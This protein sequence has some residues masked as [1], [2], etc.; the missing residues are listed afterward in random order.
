[1]GSRNRSIEF[2]NFV[3]NVRQL[4]KIYHNTKT[5]FQE[6]TK[7]GY[8][9]QEQLKDIQ[10][11]ED[12]NNR[13]QEIIDIC[14]ELE[15]DFDN[16][17]LIKPYTRQVINSYLV[18]AATLLHDSHTKCLRMFVM[19]AF[20]MT[21]DMMIT[22]KRIEYAKQNEYHLYNSLMAIANRK[23]EEIKDIISETI[24]S[25]KDELIDE[26][27]NYKFKFNNYLNIK[28]YTIELSASPDR[29]I[30]YRPLHRHPRR[31]SSPP[32]G[33]LSS[34]DSSLQPL[35]EYDHLSTERSHDNCTNNNMM[36][37]VADD[38]RENPCNTTTTTT[39]TATGVGNHNQPIV[40][41]NSG[42]C[43][44]NSSYDEE[45][46]K[47]FPPPAINLCEK[48]P[49]S[50]PPLPSL[51]PS[52]ALPSHKQSETFHMHQFN[53]SLSSGRGSGSSSF[54]PLIDHHHV[55]SPSRLEGEPITTALINTTTD[56]DT[57][58]SSSI[59]SYV[60]MSSDA[61]DN[62]Y[63]RHLSA[64]EIQTAM[65][66]I[67]DMI[68]SKLNADIAGKL[69]GSVDWLRSS[70][71]G[72]LERCLESLEILPGHKN[73]NSSP[74]YSSASC[75]TSSNSSTSTSSSSSSSLLPISA[76][77][78]PA[79]AVNVL[80]MFNISGL[81]SHSRR[82]SSTI[83]NSSMINCNDHTAASN[84]LKQ[85]LNAAY[86]VEINMKATSSLVSTFWEKMKQ[87]VTV[88]LSWRNQLII[89][90][91]WKRKVAIDVFNSLSE[92][93]LAKSICAQF[94]E[95]L[96]LSHE[97]FAAAMKH[98]ESLHSGRLEKTEEQRVRVRKYFAPRIARNALESTSLRDTVLY[99]MPQLDREI[100][101][102]QYGVVYSCE[103]WAGHTPVAIKSVV[104]PDEKHLN[105]LAMEFYYTRSIPNH[106]RIVQIR[107]SVIDHSYGGGATPAVLLVMDR[108]SRDLYSAI[109]NGL[110]WLSRLQVAIDVVQGI[111]FLHSQGLVHR[112]IK[113]KNVLLDKRNR[114]KITDLGFCKPGAMMSGSIVGTPIH[115]APELFT[116]K[117]DNSVDVYAFG[118]LFWY[119]CAG[120]VRLPYVFEQ[121]QN[122]DQLWSC[123]RKGVR[124]ERLPQF[125]D[126]CWAI[127]EACWAKD[128]SQRPL[129][130]DIEPKLVSILKKYKPLK[131]DRI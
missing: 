128:P 116:G 28:P 111:R 67:Q 8:F 61:L 102:G 126:D 83:H 88:S 6:I 33:T 13:L 97:Q 10:L 7:S 101:R 55:V 89:D 69:I 115:M 47:Y 129:L 79:T 78:M 96:R 23:Q 17:K 56:S 71:I 93:R 5:D 100:G 70:Y 124:P 91:D 25:L 35:I 29:S 65:A 39:T 109:K 21:R 45:I 73:H 127:M 121:C 112:D 48:P 59:S 130:G 86:Q 114:A 117:Y 90:E 95:R 14:G 120:H 72:T 119:I 43:L 53:F 36:I 27:A 22:P 82:N 51:A 16:F 15:N 49:P 94:K 57:N 87:L 41:T 30:T 26:A 75:S 34:P 77:N 98:L 1:M 113:L 9:N 18:D 125:D 118:I 123:V 68:L 54:P 99:G 76:S 52:I 131:P 85:I 3:D 58:S 12:V 92:S 19:A 31:H 4:R 64:R 110:D 63:R 38:Y 81:S 105:D 46:E 37:M 84:A 107:G 62:Y 24:N 40:T 80:T 74:S 2:S 11:T 42:V 20:D 32:R 50:T 108:L 44:L 104:P 66:E 103:S 122:K 106:E 60:I